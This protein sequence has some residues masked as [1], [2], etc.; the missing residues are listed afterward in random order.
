MQSPQQASPLTVPDSR[1]WIPRRIILMT[2]AVVAVLVGFY[3][4]YR[5]TN[6]L[7]IV[8]VAA[9]L[10]TA[11]RPAVLWLER[12]RIPQ[13]GGILLIYALL[14]AL[15][16]GVGVSMV[17][18]LTDQ[19]ANL[20][21]HVPTYYHDIRE[22]L[23]ASNSQL[24]TRLGRELPQEMSLSPLGTQAQNSL[25]GQT[26]TT[27]DQADAEQP[28][29]VSQAFGYVRSMTWSIFGVLAVFLIAFFWTRDR[30]QI[31]G[32][33]LLIVPVDRRDEAR[34]LWLTVEQKVGGYVRGEALLMLSIGV[35]S[36]I[37]FLIIGAPSALLMAVLAGLFEAIQVV[38]PILSGA[39][40]VIITLANAP[41]KVIWV[42]IAC[43]VIQ[44]LENAV[45]VPRIMGSAVGVN[46]LVTL[47]AITAFGSLL[48]V[49]GAIL[50]IP[51]AAIIQVLLDHWV[52]NRE[53]QPAVTIEGRDKTAVVRYLAQDLAQDLRDRI[54]DKPSDQNQN[55]D[56]FEEEMEILVG[57]IDEML[58]RL[59]APPEP[60]AV[61]GLRGVTR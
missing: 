21:E 20:I 10:A 39:V 19:G 32:S 31:I 17:P 26:Q 29:L 5:F 28:S 44:Q 42:L 11:M 6:V 25:G 46:P 60:P 47:L 50:A 22:Q 53:S 35:L 43:V 41:D 4:L 2:L 12:H 38:G 8:F 34:D 52:L 37:A 24:L 18:L 40:A 45:L 16:I 13:A 33:M 51:L 59:A 1:R 57:N 48:G 3:L 55:D 30:D 14:I 23:I 49:L 61:T 7:F 56:S 36:A 58:E 9:V 15:T 27:G 54:R